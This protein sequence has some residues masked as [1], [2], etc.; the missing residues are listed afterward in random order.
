MISSKTSLELTQR[1]TLLAVQWLRLHLPMQGVW[2]QS[3]VREL[4]SHM[5]RGQKKL[6][7]HK[8]EAIL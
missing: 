5:P 8:T 4:R 3:L 2:V 7:K 6:P 1:G